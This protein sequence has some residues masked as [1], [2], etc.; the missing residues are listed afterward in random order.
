MRLEVKHLN[1]AY[2]RGQTVMKDISFSAGTGEFLSVLG[3]NG[4]GKSTLFRCILSILTDYRGSIEIDG[5]DV[6]S[7]SERELASRIAYIPQIHRPTFGYSVLD[8]VLMGASR[9]ISPFSMPKKEH[10]KLAMEMLERL[11]IAYLAERNF[12]LL[13]GGEQQLVL[14]ARAMAQQADILIMDEPTSALDYGNQLRVLQEVKNLS[15]EG[16]TVLL[17]THNPQHAMSFA[18]SVL[19]LSRGWVAAHGPANEVLTTELVRE[20]YNVD[21]DFAFVGED[22]VM[23]PRVI[24]TGSQG[25]FCLV[26]DKEGETE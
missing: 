8:T 9:Q 24:H 6:K 18:D 25:G 17:S 22:R 26:G 21:V 13:S 20:L 19:A 23:I 11:G 12:A 4:A 1:F 14:V 3:P 5:A 7:L 10:R 2:R 16:Y 15:K